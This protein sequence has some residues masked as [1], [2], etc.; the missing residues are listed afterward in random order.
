MASCHITYPAPRTAGCDTVNRPTVREPLL[1]Q[2]A[3]ITSTVQCV[4]TPVVDWVCAH[5]DCGAPRCIR[6]LAVTY[7][8]PVVGFRSAGPRSAK[9]VK[10]LYFPF[11]FLA[12]ACFG[13]WYVTG[14]QLVPPR[15]PSI[16][17][18]PTLGAGRAHHE[19][20]G[21]LNRAEKCNVS[22][23]AGKSQVGIST[24]RDRCVLLRAVWHTP[25][26]RLTVRTRPTHQ[27]GSSPSFVN[28][29]AL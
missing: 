20:F 13:P 24:T 29:R 4:A 14:T 23:W 22:S 5:R 18:A 10:V 11:P 1:G 8:L 19:P 21:L 15:C 25:L 27:R 6:S 3:M 2:I 28:L 17:I 12:V 26:P 7:T 16:S 9:S